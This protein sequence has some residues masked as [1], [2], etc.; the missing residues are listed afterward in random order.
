MTEGEYV[1]ENRKEC[2]GFP[3]IFYQ[4]D[5]QTTDVSLNICINLMSCQGVVSSGSN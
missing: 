4:S 3:I 1:G 5:A 2:Q